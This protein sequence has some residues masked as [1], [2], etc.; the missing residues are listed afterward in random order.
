MNSP[1]FTKP[2]DVLAFL[3][4]EF[5]V[6]GCSEEDKVSEEIKKFL[7]WASKEDRPNFET[8]YNNDGVYYLI[9]STMDRLG[10]IDHGISIRVPF[11]TQKGKDFLAGLELDF[12]NAT[13]EAYDG[14]TY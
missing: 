5:G 14:C 8:L 2:V 9:A 1:D 4:S 11:I 6:C 12:A 3:T 10:L 13:G 7:V